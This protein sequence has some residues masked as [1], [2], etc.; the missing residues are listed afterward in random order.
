MWEHP[1][2]ALLCL[3]SLDSSIMNEPENIRMY[4]ALLKIKAK[5]K[6]YIPHES[7]SL[8]KS[9]V[10]YYEGYGTPDQLMEAY[11]Y[12]GSA[13]RDMGDAPRAVRAFQDAAD[14]GKDSKRYDI[15]GRVYEQMGYRLAYQGLYDEALEAYRKSYEYKMY[16]K[17]KGEVIALRNIARIYNCQARYRQCYIL[18]S[19]CL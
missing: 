10:Q 19:I 2:S 17:G 11:Y 5:D 8:L 7:D 4:H 14:I 1:D 15:L 9:I 13:Y 18:L 16:D 3:S 12:L 6:L